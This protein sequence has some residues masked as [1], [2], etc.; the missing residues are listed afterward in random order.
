MA[1][2]EN[3]FKQALA[4]GR[5]QIGLWTSLADPYAIEIVASAGFDWLVVD[6]EHG[7]NDLRSVL[8]QLQAVAPY[9]V[10]PVVRLP[11]GDPVLIKQYLDTGAHSLLIPMVE[12]GHQAQQLVAATRYAPRGIRGVASARASRWGGISDYFRR[13]N[14]L[15][16]L[17]PQVETAKGLEDLD[18]IL[19]VEGVDGVFIGPSDLAASLGHLGNPGHPDVV[20][21]IE[22]AISRIVASGKAAGILTADTAL[23]RRYIELGVRFCAVG[24]DTIMLAQAARSL[25][26]KFKDDLPAVA[27]PKP[28]ATY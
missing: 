24:I 18:E 19:A 1:M 10:E 6:A 11:V 14:E 9:S 16:C 27:E 3:R 28:G 13:A 22:G 15:V 5:V 12:S 20:S 25:A 26:R 2:I 21:A 17:L 8:G 7:P 23:A 4:A